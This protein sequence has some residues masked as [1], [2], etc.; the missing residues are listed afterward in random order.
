[1]TPLEKVSPAEVENLI[2]QMAE[3]LQPLLGSDHRSAKMLGIKTGGVLVAQQLHSALYLSEPAG[4]LNISFYR[5]DFSRIGLHP[6]VGAS[7]IPFSVDGQII[8]LV[9]DVLYSG[10][11]VRAAMNEIFDFGRPEKII[12]ATLVER[13]G[14]ELPVS[15]DVIGRS[16]D[17][18]ES[19]QVKLRSDMS[20]EISQR[21]TEISQQ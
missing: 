20:L 3:S 9:D 19:H 2:R 17:L 10:R 15:A 11:T 4:E 6:Q 16:M 8:I 7:T 18:P 12:L 1:M 13:S 5:D 14:R 21:Q